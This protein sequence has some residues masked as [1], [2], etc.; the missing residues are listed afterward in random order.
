LKEF[1]LPDSADQ[2]QDLA[3]L[4]TKLAGEV[5]DFRNAHYDEL[6]ADQRAELEERIEQLYDFHDQFAGDAIQNTL[7]AMQGDL[8]LLTD[9]TTRATNALKHLNAIAAVVNIVSAAATLAEDIVIGDYGAIP[10]AVR[11]LA[12]VIQNPSD[13][14][15]SGS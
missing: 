7:N 4:F 13:K 9:A 12:Q 10:E 5:D 8:N 14:K 1:R 15:S 11:V 2:A 3:N 6:T